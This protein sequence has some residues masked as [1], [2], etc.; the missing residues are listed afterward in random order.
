MLEKYDVRLVTPPCSPLAETSNAMVD[1]EDDISDLLPYVNAE[2]KQCQYDPVFPYLRFRYRDKDVILHP[3]QI[4]IKQLVDR[5][6]A[7]GIAQGLVDMLRDIAKRRD[8]IEPRHTPSPQVKAF[9]VFRLL[10]RTNCGLCGEITCLAFAAK[11]AAGDA[12][13]DKCSP[14]AQSENRDEL[15]GLEQLLSGGRA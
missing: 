9:D 15:E 1:F 14:L 3:H 2:M 12:T 10:P 4:G 7:D 8:Q 11:L 13:T 6:E 5:E